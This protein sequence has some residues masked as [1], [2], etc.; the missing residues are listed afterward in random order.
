MKKWNVKTNSCIVIC[1]VSWNKYDTYQYGKLC[2]VPALPLL[3][4]FTR[5]DLTSS[6]PD[7][8]FHQ[9]SENIPPDA[10]LY[11]PV[12]Q[13]MTSIFWS[14]L[15]KSTVSV[16]WRISSVRY[17]MYFIYLFISF[18]LANTF[19]VHTS[20]M[21][22]EIIFPHKCQHLKVTVYISKIWFKKSYQ[23]ISWK[24]NQNFSL[25]KTKL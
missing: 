18:S 21:K 22:W 13:F 25:F 14:C 23:H 6:S 24:L 15:K 9:E 2:I 7:Q 8:T 16:D 1:I 20:V 10:I 4:I 3:V 5:P 19:F 11:L 17:I 12:I